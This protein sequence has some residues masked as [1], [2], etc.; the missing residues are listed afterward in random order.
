MNQETS[1]FK[2]ALTVTLFAFAL[3]VAIVIY[4][5]D[6]SEQFTDKKFSFPEEI[7]EAKAGSLL[8]VERVTEDSI[9]L[10]FKH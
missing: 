4:T 1:L 2:L 5:N 3:F 6:T 7:S 9:Y 10:G 8:K